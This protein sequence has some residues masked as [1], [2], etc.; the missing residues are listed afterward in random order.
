MGRPEAIFAQQLLGVCNQVATLYVR[1]IDRNQLL[2]SAMAGLYEAARLPVPERLS[3]EVI[4]TRGEQELFDLLR[5]CREEIGNPDS[6]SGRQALV[7]CCQALAKTLD[8][9]SGVV[10]AEE[11]RK[12]LGLE[13]EGVGV[14][15]ELA[16]HLG[17]AEV[18]VKM[19]HPGSP[20]QQAGLRPDDRIIQVAGRP[21]SKITEE[22]LFQRL[23]PPTSSEI[24]EAPLPPIRPVEITFRRPGRNQTTTLTLM[25]QRYRVEHIQGVQRQDDQSWSYWLDARHKL[26]HIRLVALGAGCSQQLEEVLAN[27][28]EEEVRGVMLDLRW[29][30]GGYLNE[31]IDVARLFLKDGEIAR[32]RM[33]TQK[34]QV[35]ACQQEGPFVD[36]PLVVLVNGETM[37]GAELIAAALQDHKR[38]VVC[39]QRSLGKGSVQTP[40][41]LGVGQVGM[42]LTSGTFIRPS[43][44]N[45]HRFAE[46]KD[47]DDWGVLPERE[48]ELPVSA[49]FSK[50]LRQAWLLYSL[51]PTNSMERLLLDDP[52][53][54]PQRE[55]ALAALRE[56]INPRT[57][58]V[59]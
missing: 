13:Q 23:N 38:A 18:L 42:K 58:Q 20:A 25:P 59:R 48:L 11:Q 33:R 46:S 35:Y 12:T 53:T 56:L 5:H 54:D 57:A 3:F 14:G 16:E 43:G 10:T 45:L 36:T 44:K 32:V 50:A 26:A 22:Q 8:S 49:D 7:V 17:G 51:R 2:C 47:R 4:S 39:G 28:H 41:H 55:A 21:V 52:T 19:V 15:L 24:L 29:C 30:P 9:Y 40:V 37:G 6:L 34:E 1:P 27:L 31:A